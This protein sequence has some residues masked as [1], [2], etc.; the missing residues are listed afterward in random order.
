MKLHSLNT[1][2]SEGRGLKPR[3]AV[4]LGGRWQLARA[5]TFTTAHAES[6]WPTQ[7]TCRWL[8]I[9]PSQSS[10]RSSVRQKGKCDQK[11]PVS[12]IRGRE[13]KLQIN[14]W[15]STISQ[16]FQENSLKLQGDFHLSNKLYLTSPE[17]SNVIATVLLCEVALF[18]PCTELRHLPTIWE[19]GI[20]FKTTYLQVEWVSATSLLQS[21]HKLH[22]VTGRRLHPGPQGSGHP[23]QWEG[24]SHGWPVLRSSSWH[25]HLVGKSFFKSWLVVAWLDGTDSKSNIPK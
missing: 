7:Q 12:L 15:T 23:S 19:L 14:F 10:A 13:T 2:P 25:M 21:K 24:A 3:G 8:Q 20:I 22:Q 18:P 5:Y 4:L 1:S 16:C 17:M 6:R 9:R 11:V